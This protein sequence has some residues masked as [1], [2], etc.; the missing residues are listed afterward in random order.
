MRQIKGGLEGP[1]QIDVA[2][3]IRRQQVRIENLGSRLALNF[4]ILYEIG[5]TL[6]QEAYEVAKFGEAGR[7]IVKNLCYLAAFLRPG[8][9]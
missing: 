5:A 3:E 6:E 4:P 9:S 8:D 1:R 2:A 7:D